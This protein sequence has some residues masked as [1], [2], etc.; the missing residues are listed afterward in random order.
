MMPIMVYMSNLDF[1]LTTVIKV[2]HDKTD[3]IIEAKLLDRG[4][5]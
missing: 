1:S 4:N 2:D 5:S 3:S